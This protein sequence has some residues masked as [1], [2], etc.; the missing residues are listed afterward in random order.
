MSNHSNAASE[1]ALRKKLPV[2]DLVLPAVS[3]IMTKLLTLFITVSVIAFT[4]CQAPQ[5]RPAAPPAVKH[6]SVNGTSLAYVEQGQGPPVVFVHGA[7][8]D[9]R[10]WERQREGFPKHYRY[11]AITQRYHGTDPW[12]DNGA[13]F[14][15]S[16]HA[17]DLAAFIRE[18]RAGPV[19]LVGW[20]YSG[21]ILFDVA[22]R[23]PELVRSLFIF[24]PSNGT[25]VTD[26]ADKKALGIDETAFGVVAEAIKAGDNAAA[27]GRLVDVVSNAP[28][29]WDASSPA[30]R[31]VLLDN[32]RAMPLLF[33]APPPPAI[34]CEQLGQIKI[35]VAIVRGELTRPLF[36]IIADTASRCIPGSQ[37]IVVPKGGHLWPGQDP[38]AFNETLLGFL[39]SK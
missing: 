24:E 9:Y 10:I 17:D 22:I 6:M 37:L 38:V 19:H 34:T 12:V 5:D 39:K 31:K 26:A 33:G 2:L 20:S 35:P 36:R 18:L 14:S 1:V 16:T 8:A 30:M 28:G 27:A 32:A 21:Q 29:T 11:I 15:A 13:K 3:A 25:F 23:H 7:I 4:G